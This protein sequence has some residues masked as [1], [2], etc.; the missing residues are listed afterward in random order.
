MDIT[1]I[2]LDNYLCKRHSVTLKCTATLND[3][4]L[5]L[6]ASAYFV[7]NAGLMEWAAHLVPKPTSCN[8]S[9]ATGCLQCY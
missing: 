2:E 5:P 8:Y 7:S 9:I 1:L 6:I 3:F 4:S